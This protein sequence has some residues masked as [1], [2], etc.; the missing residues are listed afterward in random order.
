MACDPDKI[1]RILLNLLANAVKFTNND[2]S[3]SVSI[4]NKETS[5]IVSV[6]D[7]GIGIPPEKTSLIFERFRQVDQSTSRCS[8][9]SGIGLSLV[10]SFVKMHSGTISINSVPGEGS[11]FIIELP[12]GIAPE[13]QNKT[14]E[15][16]PDRMQYFEKINIEFSDIYL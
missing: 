2:G 9:G 3:I 15:Y 11:D 16:I 13:N 7:T 6:K 14:R 8:E 1:E 10:Q 12:A 5:V 4:V